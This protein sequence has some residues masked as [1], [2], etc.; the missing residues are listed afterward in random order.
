MKADLSSGL[1]ASIAEATIRRSSLFHS[2]PSGKRRFAA[3]SGVPLALSP[4]SASER[5]ATRRRRR[6]RSSEQLTAIRYSQVPKLARSWKRPNRQWA[7]RKVSWTTSSASC[8][9]PVIR[10]AR[11]KILRL[12]RSTSAPKAS[13]SPARAFATAAASRSSIDSI[14]RRSPA[15]VGFRGSYPLA[16][17]EARL[18]EDT[19]M[20]RAGGGTWVQSLLRAPPGT[21][22]LGRGPTTFTRAFSR[23]CGSAIGKKRLAAYP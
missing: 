16:Q 1:S 11:R 6:I 23:A 17:W 3:T 5:S 22:L 12:W 13:A 9:F 8:S 14:R 2:S 18:P 7:R 21:S 4:S 10:Y 19:R 15:E 20:G